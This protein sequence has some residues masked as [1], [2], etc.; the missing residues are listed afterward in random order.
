MRIAHVS[1][2]YFP[3]LG[4]IERQV[5]DLAERQ[6]ALGHDVDIITAVAGSEPDEGPVRIVRPKRGLARATSMRTIGAF[7]LGGKTVARADYDV[8]HLHVSALSMM[9]YRAAQIGS[10]L[11]IPCVITAHSL[12]DYTT[13]I[14]KASDA[15]L[16]WSE[17]PI[18]WSAVSS[19]AADSLRSCLGPDRP[20]GILPNGIDRDAWRI[21][22]KPRD[23]KRVVVASV[24]RLAHRKRPHQLLQMMR[25]AR[26]QVP[27]DIRLELVII[28]DGPRRPAIERDIRRHGMS[29]WVTLTG[30]ATHQ[31]I[32]HIYADV[33]FAVAPATLESFGIAALEARCAGLPVVAH[34][35]SGVRDFVSHGR[36]GLLAVGDDDMARCIA[37][38]ASSPDLLAAMRAHNRNS[39]PDLDLGW[40]DVLDRCSQLYASAGAPV[41]ELDVADPEADE[42]MFGT[43]G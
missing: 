7:L 23:P 29:D 38:L 43:A 26:E 40:P 41:A 34:A 3:R 42:Q 14:F 25:Q 9:T 10:R 30:R 31:Q 18:T 13:P 19:V 36:E 8:L 35:S 37:Q 39:A 20:I 28:G 11:G 33:D 16:R 22:P 12:W 2:C 6:H 1:D 27:D 15:M 24:M 32:R 4:G 5:N 21:Q 17:W